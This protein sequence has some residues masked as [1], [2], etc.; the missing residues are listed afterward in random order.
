VIK[1]HEATR[2][3]ADPVVTTGRSYNV[4][5]S[6]KLKHLKVPCALVPCMPVCV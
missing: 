1:H 3:Q 5:L 2:G 4:V 6:A